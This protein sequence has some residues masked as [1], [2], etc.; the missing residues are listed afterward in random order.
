MTEPIRTLEEYAA[1][2]SVCIDKID[3][4]QIDYFIDILVSTMEKNRNIFVCGNGGSAAIAEHLSCDCMKGVATDTH[5]R[6]RIISLASNMSVMTA[7]A[8]DFGYEHTFSAQLEFQA[9]AGDLLIVISSSGNSPNIISALDKAKELGLNTVAIVGFSG[10]EA[11]NR[12]EI[13]IHIDIDNYGVIEDAS[14]AVMHFVAQS[15]RW[16]FTE[17]PENEINY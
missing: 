12:S 10:G 4:T 6:P 2:L 7:I 11:A 17:K 15:I 16:L 8:N 5:L 13:V 1:C 3:E 14:Q 9:K